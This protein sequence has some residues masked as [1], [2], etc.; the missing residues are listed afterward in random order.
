[1]K[2][3]GPR[4]GA[5]ISLVATET[6]RLLALRKATE[7]WIAATDGKAT[8]LLGAGGAT[9]ALAGMQAT[10]GAGTYIPVFPRVLIG[11]FG[12]IGI[13]SCIASVCCLWPRTDR[14]RALRA[15]GI[16]PLPRSPSVFWELGELDAESFSAITLETSEEILQRDA[17]ERLMI[18]TWV[19][20]RKMHWLK[21]A[22]VLYMGELVALI[23]AVLAAITMT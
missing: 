12:C 19:A 13:L 22:T 20:T 9:L 1:M 14:K 17:L 18:A 10:Q 7:T 4:G 11:M 6:D 2:R 15:R 5:P 3:G 21:I 8:A 16:M 23:L